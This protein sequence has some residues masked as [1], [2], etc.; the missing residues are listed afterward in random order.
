MTT[1]INDYRARKAAAMAYHPA[2]RP[3]WTPQDAVDTAQAFAAELAHAERGVPDKP[4][5]TAKLFGRSRF[6]RAKVYDGLAVGLL[7]VLMAALGVVV[8]AA[9]A[10]AE[11]DSDALA[12]AAEYG[13]AVCSVLDDYP[14]VSGMLGIMQAIVEDGMT[15]YQAGQVVG[16]SIYRLCPEYDYLAEKFMRRYGGDSGQVGMI[17][18]RA[19]AVATSFIGAIWALLALIYANDQDNIFRDFGTGV[20]VA[21]AG[22]AVWF[23]ADWWEHR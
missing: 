1:N 8:F 11:P 18:V 17:S 4:H 16:I 14:S 5:W 10:K 6:R 13:P 22:F 20:A 7:M 21:A 3:I 9:S 15:E 23:I 12:Y 19:A 2:V